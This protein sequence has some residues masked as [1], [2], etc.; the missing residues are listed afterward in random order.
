LTQ[1]RVGEKTFLNMNTLGLWVDK[2]WD[3]LASVKL[4]IVI[5]L[6]LLLL[7]VPGTVVMQY[8]ISNIDP[9]I[10]YSYDFW[11][12]GQAIQLFTSYHSFWYVG[13]MALLSLNLIAC[14]VNRWPQMLRLAVAKPVR[15]SLETFKKHPSALQHAWRT[16]LSKNELR[17]KVL[18]KVRSPWATAPVVLEDTEKSLQI[19]WQV[20]RWSR[21]ANYLVHTSLLVIFSG[22]IVSALYGFEGAANIPS[23]DAVDTLIVFKEGKLNKLQPA[24]GGLINEKMLGYRLRARDFRVEFYEDWPGRPKSFITNLQIL[25]DGVPVKEKRITVND[26]LDYEGVRFYQASYGRL[27]DFEIQLRSIDKARPL[28]GQIFRKIKLGEAFTLPQFN[29]QLVALQALMDVQGFGPGVQFQELKDD[30]PVGQPFWSLQK[31]PEYD[32]ANREAPYALV[33]DDV[34]ELFF[35]GLQIGYDP[36]APIYWWGCFGML[37]GTF[38]ALFMTHRKYYLHFQDGEIRFAGSIHRLPFGFERAV[39]QKAEELKELTGIKA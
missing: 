35:T 15:W 19:F 18:A 11:R 26:P 4:T 39:A 7:A 37:V 22:A 13:L 17:E 27:G 32:F 36:G 3:S 12:F 16:E 10:Q 30:Q 34:R 25:R 1:G 9:G 38:Y 31:H 33:L 23:G 21:I 8:N 29:T 6:G 2:A 24:P 14:S 5:L 20:G 28:V